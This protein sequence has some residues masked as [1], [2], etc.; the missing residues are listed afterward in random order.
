MDLSGWETDERHIVVDDDFVGEDPADLFD[1]LTLFDSLNRD[2]MTE[3]IP[4]EERISTISGS[5]DETSST[6]DRKKNVIS[7]TSGTKETRR[8]QYVSSFCH[9]F[10]RHCVYELPPI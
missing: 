9:D 6:P 5:T 10:P 4:V 8:F 3:C 7:V 2:H 1:T